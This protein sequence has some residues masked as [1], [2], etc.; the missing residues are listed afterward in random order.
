MLSRQNQ[1]SSSTLLVEGNFFFVTLYVEAK[2]SCLLTMALA[3]N[4]VHVSAFIAQHLLIELDKQSYNVPMQISI[5]NPPTPMW[6]VPHHYL[7]NSRIP[8]RMFCWPW[9][10]GKEWSYSFLGR[11][12]S[13]WALG[14]KSS[15]HLVETNNYYPS[16]APSLVLRPS[17]ISL[18]S[19]HLAM[20]LTFNGVES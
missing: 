18:G 6:Y 5:V 1:N 11:C 12:E 3:L 16:K 15:F 17:D 20:A 9:F 4:K 14:G 7:Q 19:Q 2:V 10:L 13:L 8:L